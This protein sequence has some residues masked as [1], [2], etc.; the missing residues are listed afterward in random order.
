MLAEEPEC[1][2]V[3][4]LWQACRCQL[5]GTA[6]WVSVLI[7]W[8]CYGGDSSG[9]QW[10]C[11]D[12]SSCF[13]PGHTEVERLKRGTAK[14]LTAHSIKSHH[15]S[16]H[17]CSRPPRPL[18]LASTLA[19]PSMGAAPAVPL[20]TQLSEPEWEDTNWQSSHSL[21]KQ[22]T[23]SHLQA[24]SLAA[25]N[26]CGGVPFFLRTN[27]NMYK[28]SAVLWLDLAT[29]CLTHGWNANSRFY[30]G[31]RKKWE[32]PAARHHCSRAQP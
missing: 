17:H 28:L 16:H 10:P 8:T 25:N 5:T 31:R 13:S 14:A 29:V 3:L 7:S 4:L 1:Q 23:P 30:V 21:L 32:E 24:C 27:T 2:F 11:T 26:S 22:I 12:R 6:T 9:T 19:G 20:P 15:P 18:R